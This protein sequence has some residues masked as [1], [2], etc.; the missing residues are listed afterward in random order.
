MTDP[1]LPPTLS[2][3]PVRDLVI[4]LVERHPKA[5]LLLHAARRR[6][7]EIGGKWRVVFVDG[8]SAAAAIGNQDFL[9][10]LFARAEQMGGEV[11]QIDAETVESGMLQV[12]LAE[13]ERLAWVVV[14]G[15]EPRRSFTDWH[16]PKMRWE[17][18]IRAAKLSIR[19]EQ[20]T[21]GTAPF[22]FPLEWPWGRPRHFVYALVSVAAAYFITQMLEQMLPPALFR[23][24]VQNI[25]LIFMT[26][27]AFTAG[28]YGLL[29]GVLAGVVGAF[30]YNYHYV[31]PYYNL[32]LL[33]ITKGMSFALFLFAATLIAIFTGQARLYGERNARREQ[34]T[35]ALFT[36]YQ[37]A[38]TAFS[39]QQALEILQQK[40][41]DM[42]YVDVAFFLPP[43]L[44]PNAIELA[45]P[46]HLTLSE[47]DSK[48]LD[49]CWQ[50]MKT[51]GLSTTHYPLARWRF[52]PMVAPS[53]AIGVFAVRPSDGKPL[54]L[55][56]LR[57]LMS[58]TDQTAI[59]IEHFELARS[60]ET[61]RISE[62]R[63][64]LR[65]MLL[66]SVSHDLKTPLAGIIGSLNVYRSIGTRLAPE[67][68][69][70][71]LDDALEEAQRLNSFITNILDITRL[72]SGRVKFHPEWQDMHV[73][74]RQVVKRMQRRLRSRSVT[75][76]PEAEMVEVLMDG[77]MTG[78]I[79]QNL[80]DNACNYTASGTPIDITIAVRE[81][82]LCCAVRDY[83]DGIPDDKLTHIFDK[84]ARL[85]KEDSQV[86]GTGL[87]LSIC[88]AVL[89]AQGGWITAANHPEGGALFTFCFPQ[90]RYTEAVDEPIENIA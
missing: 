50:D 54:E 76:I 6:A 5:I 44:N 60:M 66:S 8:S 82:G 74:V 59:I 71:L 68:R 58:I 41:A 31:P 56:K 43:V 35:Q 39:R 69:E 81:A 65:A 21:L 84:Y 1:I 4:A 45:L 37:I 73:L 52:K 48:A 32:H 28:R 63:E 86:A 47:Y 25:S 80:I 38:S 13:M 70:E 36:L 10:R 90:W 79:L 67:R 22:R 83:G 72:E 46:A 62:E 85:Q 26:A 30:V 49:T 9:F 27:C 42:L 77:V 17:L 7:R 40:L 16:V 3:P 78:Q 19:I 61:A 24:N 23:I 15:G 11:Q 87:G 51:A 75:I 57:L 53:G 18:A 34:S 33:S 55:W 89:E 2:P 12:V 88:K 14:G 29:P 64:K 20:V